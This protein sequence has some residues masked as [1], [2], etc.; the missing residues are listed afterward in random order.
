MS[1]LGNDITT[2]QKAGGH[3]LAVAG[4]TLDHLVVRL[5]ARHGDVLNRVG[6]VRGLF[7][8]DDRRVSN[9]REV[10]TGV[11]DQVGLKFVEINVQ[12]A[13][14]TQGSGDGRD[15]LGDQAVEVLVAGALNAEVAA[16]DI[17]D[18]LIVD[19]EATV[20]V[21][22]SSVSGE[23]RVVGLDDGGSV[24]GGG[25][26]TELEL[27]LLAVVDRETLHQQST[28]TGTGTTTEGV[29]D[30]E[31]LETRARVCHAANLVQ[32]LVDHLLTNGVVT[33]GIVV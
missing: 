30:E 26:N 24:L 1:V 11:G 19:H 32:N 21:L 15:N 12:G 28:E 16:A 9:Q 5:E 13:I 20:G 23:D 7:G 17:V 27:G 33:T 10:N 29:E 18:S 2:V 6:F 22:K 3:V 25:V 31:A 4:V 14:E 8:G